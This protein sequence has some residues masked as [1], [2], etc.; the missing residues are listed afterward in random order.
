MTFSG[1][2]QLPIVL[3]H[4]MPGVRDDEARHAC[5]FERFF[6]HEGGTTPRELTKRGLYN[7]IAIRLK[8][9]P[10]RVVGSVMVVNAVS[11]A[12]L[13]KATRRS[14][15]S[16]TKPSSR[17]SDASIANTEP[18]RCPSSRGRWIRDRVS[19]IFSPRESRKLSASPTTSAESADHARSASGACQ[20]HP[21]DKQ[22]PSAPRG[23]GEESSHTD[24]GSELRN[25]SSLAVQR[26]TAITSCKKD[27]TAAGGSIS[28]KHI[29][30]EEATPEDVA[31]YCNAS[32]TSL[33]SSNRAAPAYGDR[34]FVD[35]H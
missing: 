31:L 2:R 8:G 23:L 6:E 29:S 34:E 4:E 26:V 5:R 28:G 17:R 30:I 33:S 16:S 32:V 25:L 21:L 19:H 35:L 24:V 14:T 1:P 7:Q 12:P 22:Y 11:G 10:W 13:A 9:G 27:S 18:S 15:R 20:V 3:V